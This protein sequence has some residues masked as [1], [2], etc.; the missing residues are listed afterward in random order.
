MNG[1]SQ[2]SITTYTFTN[3]T[4]N[5]TIVATFKVETFTITPTAGVHGTIT[6]GT[7]QTVNLR[8]Q[9]HLYDRGGTGLQHR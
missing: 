8:R 3:V 6:P 7:L 4:A 9:R 1:V 5:G 2:G